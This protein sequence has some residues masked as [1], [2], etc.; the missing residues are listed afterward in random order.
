MDD[1]G[2]VIAH[3]PRVAFITGPSSTSG[4]AP[5][6][7]PVLAACAVIVREGTSVDLRS[8]TR[9]IISEA[10]TSAARQAGGYEPTMSLLRLLGRVDA[11]CIVTRATHVGGVARP[12]EQFRRVIQ[13]AMVDELVD[14]GVEIVVLRRRPDN[15]LHQLDA[16]LHAERVPAGIVPG[17]VRFVQTDAVSEPLL[18]LPTAIEWAHGEQPGFLARLAGDRLR[19]RDVGPDEPR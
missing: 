7:V 17:R 10:T 16:H 13:Q 18:E 2:D 1:S 14:E 8:E 12:I 5:G 9:R 3:Q 6:G 11:R 19:Y 4:G 15:N